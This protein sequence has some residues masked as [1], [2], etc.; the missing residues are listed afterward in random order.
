MS[1]RNPTPITFEAAKLLGIPFTLG[2]TRGVILYRF[3]R[4][5]DGYELQWKDNL[6]GSRWRRHLAPDVVKEFQPYVVEMS[7][8]TWRSWSR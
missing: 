4:T 8:C 2:T 3:K 7:K 1:S 6:P 5:K